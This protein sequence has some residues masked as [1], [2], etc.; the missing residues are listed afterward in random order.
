M[1]RERAA[2]LEVTE[3]AGAWLEG[4]NGILIHLDDELGV[5]SQSRP[6]L[7]ISSW[8]ASTFARRR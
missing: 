4:A 1:T 7:G 8:R 3:E 6:K 5:T 2:D